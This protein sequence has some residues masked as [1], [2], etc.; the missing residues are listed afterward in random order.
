MEAA[1]LV[2]CPEGSRN[3]AL[4]T[5]VY[6]LVRRFVL[7]ESLGLDELLGSIVPAAQ[8]CGLVDREIERT[9]RSA[10]EAAVIH[11]PIR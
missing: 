9:V 1:S 4:N 11:G 3:D 8:G 7:T 5:V 10:V 2:A 6:K